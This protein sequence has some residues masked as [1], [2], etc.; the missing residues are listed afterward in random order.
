M[1]QRSLRRLFWRASP[2]NNNNKSD[3][4][5]SVPD[6]KIQTAIF[7]YSWRKMEA[8]AQYRAGWRRVVCGL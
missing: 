4:I 1:K 3:D 2:N 7:K 8:A 5:G 6:H